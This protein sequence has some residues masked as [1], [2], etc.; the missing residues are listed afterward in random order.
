MHP[1]VIPNSLRREA[2][3]AWEGF[4]SFVPSPRVLTAEDLRTLDYAAEHEFGIPPAVLMENAALHAARLIESTAPG[5]VLVL[6]GSGNNGGDGYALTRLLA[7]RGIYARAAPITDPNALTGPAAMNHIAALRLGLLT[8]PHPGTPHAD[9]AIALLQS[10]DHHT[11][12]EAILGTGLGRP[13]EGT[14]AELIG[15]LNDSRRT[16]TVRR[17]IALDIPSGL[18]ADSGAPLGAINADLTITFAASKQG[19]GEITAQPHLGEI[20]LVPIG[21]PNAIITRFGHPLPDQPTALWRQAHREHNRT[22]APEHPAAG[23]DATP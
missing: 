1:S 5:P 6:C 23:R 14:L 12:V 8:T 3:H 15:S 22:T 4:V 11:A 2:N 9:H 7:T 13:I 17:T 18:H 16:G 20:A 19:F 21:V 10:G